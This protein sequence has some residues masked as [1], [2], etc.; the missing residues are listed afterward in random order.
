MN[1]F[2][3]P[4]LN[5]LSLLLAQNANY[6]NS[7]NLIVDH[8]GE[9]FLEPSRQGCAKALEKYRFYF[10]KLKGKSNIGVIAARNLRYV[11]QL[12]KNLLYCW[13]H[14]IE[15]EV[16]IELITSLRTINY[17]LELN[18]ISFTSEPDKQILTGNIQPADNAFRQRSI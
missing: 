16:S 14:N 17:W 2:N 12:Y 8:D 4:T 5:E 1:L 15:G 13:D 18:R 10:S 11:N 3:S 9:V 7:Y 6:F